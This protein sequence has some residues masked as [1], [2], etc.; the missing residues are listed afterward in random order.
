MSLIISMFLLLRLSLLLLF[1]ALAV[2]QTG[3]S[4]WTIAPFNP[5][6]YSLALRSPYLNTWNAQGNGPAPLTN[7]WPNLWPASRPI[8]GWYASVVV[9]GQG[10]RIMGAANIPNVT[11]ANQTAVEFTP[12]RTSLLF[13]AGPMQINATFLNPIE[14]TDLV[15]QSLPFSY[16]YLSATSTDGNAHTLRMYSDISGE[17]MAGDTSQIAQWTP[18]DSG[19]YVVLSM[20]LQTQQAFTENDNHAQDATEYYTFKKI[21][22]TTTSW[23]ITQDV[24]NRGLAS[25]LSKPLSNTADPT[26]RPV[27]DNWPTLGIMIDWPG[28]IT[29]TPEPAVWAIGLVRNPS[30]QYRLTDGT[31]QKRS[32]YFLTAFSDVQS[33]AQFFLDDFSNALASA[34]AFD[35]KLQAAGSALSSDYADLLTLSVGQVLS[36]LDITIANGTDVSGPIAGM[37][38]QSPDLQSSVNTVDVLY[39]AF[40]MFLYLNPELGGYLLAPLLEY[41]DSAAYTQTYAAR[42]IGTAYPNATADHITDA[43]D[44]QV[45]ETANMLI[46]VL[47]Y[48]QASGNGTFIS[49]HYTLLSDWAEFLG[50]TTLTPTNQKSADVAVTGDLSNNNQTNTAL[51]GIIGIA[52]MAKMAE[53]AGVIGDQKRFNDTATSYIQQWAS[54]AVAADNSHIDFFYGD[55]NS[56][57]LMYNVFADKLLQLDLVP[58]SVYQVLTVYYNN[59][60]AQNRFGLPLDNQD[61]SVATSHSMMF[62]ASTVTNPTT[63]SFM[64]TQLHNYVSA[65][66]NNTAFT[67]AYNPTTGFGVDVSVAGVNSPAVGS[68]FSLLAL[69]ASVKSINVPGRSTVPGSAA[70]NP[71]P[72]HTGAIA[73]GVVAGVVGVVAIGVGI[74]FWIRRRRNARLHHENDYGTYSDPKDMARS[75]SGGKPMGLA[76][77]TAFEPFR[78]SSTNTGSGY[79]PSS[80][81]YSPGLESGITQTHVRST[82]EVQDLAGLTSVAAQAGYVAA[83]VPE[84]DSG[85]FRTRRRG[86]SGSDLGPSASQVGGASE[87][88]IA[89]QSLVNEELRSEVDNLRRDLERIREEQ[90]RAVL[91]EAPPSY[92]DPV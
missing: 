85:Y 72:S 38:S 5:P 27:Q 77:G 61:T 45:E 56:N 53:V 86:E 43:H 34:N 76:P 73:G 15:R 74:F 44:F 19:Q 66:L 40:P 6:A 36:S 9:D 7:V 23:G 64:V 49:N 25:N 26:P 37:F 50:N 21:A 65:N 12:T 92:S 91:D 17:F 67:A 16:F 58:E 69:N 29:E 33:A 47:A 28:S 75:Y 83:P 35:A 88:M 18:V 10:Y 51:K 3:P 31:F 14:P 8:L 84:R 82:S 13:S 11:E 89:K 20:Q 80:D 48:S 90:G 32:P 60:A 30:I 59:I 79:T 55:T 24:V 52:A 22:G 1:A 41:Q 4:L 87:V 70:A 81:L 42:N 57:G 46:M 68:M 54:N 71:S 63:Q 2:S 39:A 62:A 78:Y